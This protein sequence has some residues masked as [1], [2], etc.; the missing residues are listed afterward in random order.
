MDTELATL[1]RGVLI[2]EV[3]IA[4][5]IVALLVGIVITSRRRKQASSPK[6]AVEPPNYYADLQQQPS[7][8]PD[9][10]GRFAA[11]PG[12]DAAGAQAA[13]HSATPG[14]AP[15]GP[16]TPPAEVVASGGL[17]LATSSGTHPVNPFGIPGEGVQGAAPG[18]STDT[19]PG[20]GTN[21]FHQETYALGVQPAP[22]PV[23][24]APP[25][26]TPTPPP[27][28][29][30]AGWLPDP[31]GTPDTLRYWDGNAWTQHFAQRS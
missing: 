25:P 1:N 17:D 15:G 21:G 30:P 26:F 10:F 12:H 8:R 7:G 31:N 4:V 29:T 27:P 24:L 9:P 16:S 5:V 3:A 18:W 14:F 2:I 23:T 11:A 13:G 6:R 22:A 28:G 19:W 20:G